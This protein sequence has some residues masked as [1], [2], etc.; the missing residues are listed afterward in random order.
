MGRRR[1]GRAGRARR[2][3]HRQ[4]A[5]RG[6]VV[7]GPL[8]K[9]EEEGQ[10]LYTMY[11]AWQPWNC[12]RHWQPRPSTAVRCHLDSLVH[13]H[14][15]RYRVKPGEEG[16]D[17]ANVSCSRTYPERLV[18]IQCGR[19]TMRRRRKGFLTGR[20]ASGSRQHRQ[21]QRA[22]APHAPVCT[23]ITFK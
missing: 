21:V 4:P 12:T 2:Y 14:Q 13:F 1:G 3:H 9:R 11:E 15:R 10:Q 8:G 20:Q 5:Q 7:V 22:P 18:G 6:F 19:A 23:T 17:V 16:D